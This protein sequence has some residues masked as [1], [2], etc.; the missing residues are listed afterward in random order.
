MNKYEITTIDF[1]SPDEMIIE[2]EHKE[3]A[4][5]FRGCITMVELERYRDE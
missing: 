5:R 2:V 4:E 1:I 3:T